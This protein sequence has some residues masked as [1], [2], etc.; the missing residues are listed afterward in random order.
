MHQPDHAG[1]AAQADQQPPHPG[2]PVPC[3][4]CTVAAALHRH[5]YQVCGLSMSCAYAGDTQPAQEA[6]ASKAVL[7]HADPAACS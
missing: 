1:A 4:S 7:R 2:V 3:G 6:T 5:H